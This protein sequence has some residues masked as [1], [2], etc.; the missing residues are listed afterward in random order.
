MEVSRGFQRHG[1]PGNFNNEKLGKMVAQRRPFR[2]LFGTPC[3]TL[4]LNEYPIVEK[5][6]TARQW[7]F[8]FPTS[9]PPHK[10]AS[11]T[12]RR[13]SHIKKHPFEATRGRRMSLQSNP[14]F[15]RWCVRLGENQGKGLGIQG[16]VLV[17]EGVKKKKPNLAGITDSY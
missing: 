3:T 4:W 7:V 2:Y 12:I 5:V 6:A 8:S 10:Y 13:T 15:G 1:H 16:K 11:P 9:A 17:S 14:C